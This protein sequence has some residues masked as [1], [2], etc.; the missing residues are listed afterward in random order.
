[1]GVSPSPTFVPHN[2]VE[3]QQLQ[4]LHQIQAHA[5][6]NSQMFLLSII[7]FSPLPMSW[8]LA[9]YNFFTH[10]PLPNLS[11]MMITILIAAGPILT[12]LFLY[13]VIK[14]IIYVVKVFAPLVLSR[15]SKKED[16]KK[17][18]ELTF[19]S[20]TSKSAYATE[21][22]YTLLHT[23]ARRKD[24]FLGITFGIKKEYS[25]EIVS[26]KKE[27]IRFILAADPKSIDII[28]RSLLSFLPGLKIAE[29]GDYLTNVPALNT[30]QE[31]AKGKAA[32]VGVVELTLSSDF[33]LPLQNQKTLDK[34][35]FIS[36]LTG[37]MTNL[38]VGELI[39][40]QIV[41]TPVLSGTHNKAISHM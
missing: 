35:D 22:L 29:I 34:H 7:M 41:T 21:Q 11:P 25:L 26:T 38:D 27:G 33:A 17:F 40:F 4:L 15:F 9:I 32:H 39:S 5:F 8:K 28:K 12:L 14:F 10:L 16:D 6:S 3:Y 23:L 20:D 24:G 30:K 2:A 31:D 37:A 19:P 36:Y 1:M 13:F 18:L